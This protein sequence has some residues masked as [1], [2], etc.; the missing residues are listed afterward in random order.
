[1]HVR[2]YSHICNNCTLY[3]YSCDFFL[4]VALLE[5]KKRESFVRRPIASSIKSPAKSSIAAAIHSSP[6]SS[7]VE[8]LGS[9]SSSHGVAPST[10]MGAGYS[11]R[12]SAAV[13]ACPSTSNRTVP[14]VTVSH[15][16]N[17]Y[18]KPVYDGHCDHCGH[19]ITLDDNCL[20]VHFPM[21]LA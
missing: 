14:F 15:K 11:L 17:F 16:T 19:Y 1:M 3:T 8:S 18:S 6:S 21:I 4:Q 5:G 9:S 12:V 13:H 7:S 10:P 20:K 2:L